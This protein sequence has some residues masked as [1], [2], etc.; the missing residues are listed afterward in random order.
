MNKY[1]KYAIISVIITI[2]LWAL[3]FLLLIVDKGDRG[4]YGD[5]FGPVNALFSGLAFAG[6]II[7]LVM[8]HEELGLQRKEL[9]QTNKELAAQRE[10]FTAQTKTMQNQRFENTLYNLLSLLQGNVKNIVYSPT[11]VVAT[12]INGLDAFNFFYNNQY[13]FFDILNN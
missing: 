9:V 1:T 11:S 5:M 8:Q 3:S 7:T 12:S 6:L 2:T 13:N 4:T 10:Q